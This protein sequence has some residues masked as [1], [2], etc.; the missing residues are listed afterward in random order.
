MKLC[1]GTVQ[2][3]MD[4][5]IAG[6]KKPGIKAAVTLLNEAYSSGIR[7]FDTASAY[8][9]AEAVLGEFLCQPGIDTKE[10]KIISKLPPEVFANNSAGIKNRII[11]DCIKNS[12]EHLGL[13]KIYGYMMHNAQ[14]IYNESAMDS[15]CA[16]KQ[17][18]YADKIGVSV[19]TPQEA[20]KALENS[21]LD[22]IQVP[23]NVLDKRLFHCGFFEL[24]KEKNIEIYVRSVLLQG[25][26]VMEEKVIPAYMD[27]ARPLLHE[28][29]EICSD[30]NISPFEAAIKY[31]MK[32]DGINYI[33]IGVDN[34]EQLRDY[35]KVT[36]DISAELFNALSGHFQSVED[37]ILLPNMWR[38]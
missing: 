6:G 5:G 24:A 13:E 15:L 29:H 20:M 22:I 3:G 31:V 35:T 12:L 38:T 16:I 27:F 33:V 34:C 7:V 11:E 36:E 30:F 14:C 25:L 32:Q 9:S 10:I 19:Y 1:L 4:Y 18:G 23:F 21:D 8:G 17:K 37:K 26:L 28:F 2:L